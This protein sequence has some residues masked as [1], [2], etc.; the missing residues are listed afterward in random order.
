MSEITSDS[1]YGAQTPVTPVPQAATQVDALSRALPSLAKDL[2]PIGARVISVLSVPAKTDTSN[3]SDNNSASLNTTTSAH[4]LILMVP[5]AGHEVLSPALQQGNRL[6]VSL[7]A[8]GDDTTQSIS[9]FRLTA[10]QICQGANAKE[11]C[12]H[13]TLSPQYLGLE[14]VIT[15]SFACIQKLHHSLKNYVR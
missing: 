9:A 8:H 7:M 12:E 13:A 14:I 15:Q 5:N 3:S 4:M 10:N 6:V 1:G 2:F 11:I